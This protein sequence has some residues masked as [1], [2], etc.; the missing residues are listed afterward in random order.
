MAAAKKLLYLFLHCSANTARS[1]MTGKD[2]AA[3][4]MRP[5]EQGGRGW[6]K[7][8][9]RKVVRQDGT[10][11]TL[12]EVNDDAWVQAGEVTNGVAG[13]NSV[14]Q[15]ICYIGGLSP[16]MA[17]MDTRTPQQKEQLK[18]IVL[19]VIKSHPD[20]Q[21]LGHYQANAHKPSCPG[22]DVPAWLR[23]IGVAEKNIFGSKAGGKALA[24]VGSE[25]GELTA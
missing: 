5:I 24:L 3:Y 12:V 10:V 14:S 7:P 6:S 1:T 16:K 17:P 21:V 23:E 22:F 25:V 15:H 4:H 11:D 18:K 13:W 19:S 20:I 2:I 9:Y 8:G